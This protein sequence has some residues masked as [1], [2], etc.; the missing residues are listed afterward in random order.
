MIGTWFWILEHLAGRGAGVLLNFSLRPL[1]FFWWFLGFFG[2]VGLLLLLLLVRCLIFCCCC[3]KREGEGGGRGERGE[4]W[5][6]YPSSWRFLSGFFD[7]F[8]WLFVT[9]LPGSLKNPR[10]YS[11]IPENLKESSRIP[12]DNKIIQENLTKSHKNPQESPRITN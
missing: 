1:R 11:R 5:V 7:W 2:V 3:S 4:G 8:V 12:K 10:E 6:E 9:G